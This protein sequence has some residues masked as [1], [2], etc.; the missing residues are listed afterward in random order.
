M[1]G[2]FFLALNLWQYRRSPSPL[3]LG[4]SGWLWA[5][6][7][8]VGM[9][10][11]NLA[12]FAGL[13]LTGIA[14]GTAVAIGSGPI[15]AGLIEA[16]LSRR[17]PVAVWWLGTLLSVGGGAL[18]VLENTDGY[19]ISPLGI[20]L[21]LA[22]GLAYSSYI[23]V[24]QWL[25]LRHPP[26][27]IAFRVFTLAACLAL[28][29]AWVL[30]GPFAAGAPGWAVVGYLGLA[31]TGISYLLYGYALRHISG[32]TGVTLALAEPVAA[33][34]LAVFV[35]HQASSAAAWIGLCL[36]LAGLLLVIRVEVGTR[37]VAPGDSGGADSYERAEGN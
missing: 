10:G 16:V 19:V 15:W 5:V 9:A 4:V 17:A 37:E 6:V 25:V 2:G 18:M 32:A 14:V 27:G 34:L 36:V 26:N 7:A 20:C 1:A 11:Y 3:T 21:C 31:P 8:A 22:S 30:S 35:V 29:C 23:L 24:N 13:K 12:F 28:P 33:F